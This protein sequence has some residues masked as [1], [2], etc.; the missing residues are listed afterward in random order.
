MTIRVVLADDQTLLG[1]ALSTILSSEDDIQVVT[2]ASNGVEAIDACLNHR[3]DI[4]VLDIRMPGVDGI[5][6]AK[7][8][9]AR[10]ADIRVIMLT[11][12]SDPELV[13]AALQ[14]GVHGFLLKDSDPQAIISAVRAVN[15]GESILSSKVTGP[16]L[17]IYR[18]ALSSQDCLTLEERQGLS[19]VTPREHDVLLLVVKGA[20]NREIASKLS[21]A[22]T[23][24][25]THIAALLSKLQARDRVAL[26]LVAQR[27][28]LSS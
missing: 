15:A 5:A 9:M 3:V 19:F 14:A 18:S 4:A 17:D 24:V 21:L 8:I 27:A 28:G 22:E 6:A 25:K 11:T 26:V 13:G 23:T 7:A 10:D 2:V 20:T 16:V 1:E 12:F